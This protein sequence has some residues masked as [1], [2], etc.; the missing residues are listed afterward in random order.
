[1][2]S[3]GGGAPWSEVNWSGVNRDVVHID[4]PMLPMWGWKGSYDSAEDVCGAKGIGMVKG[5]IA[6]A[7]AQY[8]N[9]KVWLNWSTDELDVIARH[10]PGTPYG[11]GADIVSFDSYGGV[12]DWPGNTEYMLDMLY[13]QLEPGQQMGLV[14]EAHYYPDGGI[15]Y[16][17]IDYV[18]IGTLYFDWAFRHDGELNED[19]EYKVYAVAP[20]YWD[21]GTDMLG[22]KGNA[23][24]AAFY[25]NVS[26]EYPLCENV[27]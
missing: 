10:C 5:R 20:F 2:T 9:A 15:D 1:M 24:I 7:R 4:E 27:P 21:S 23:R 8:P 11:L 25:T 6:A 22:M 14:P 12:W 13:R 16:S 19:G 17:T 18:M 3:W 26:K